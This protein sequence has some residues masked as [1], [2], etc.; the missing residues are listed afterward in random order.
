MSETSDPPRNEIDAENA[1]DVTVEVAD[2]HRSVGTKQA[3]LRLPPELAAAA[4]S[5]ALGVVGLARTETHDP[6][7]VRM[8]PSP[9]LA[10]RLAAGQASYLERD[11]RAFLAIARDVESKQIV[12]HVELEHASSARGVEHAR[13]V[14]GAA[15]AWKAL[16]VATQQH[17]LVEISSGLK[18]IEAAIDDLGLDG[19]RDDDAELATATR[20]LSRVE[21]HL[22][23]GAP[24]SPAD[25]TLAERTYAAA[26]RIAD[27]RLR[28]V[29]ALLPPDADS[30]AISD[31]P[32]IMRQLGLA[33]RALAV[34]AR[35]AWLVTRL[36][37]QDAQRAMNDLEHYAERFG[38]LRVRVDDAAFALRALAEG[39]E[40]AWTQHR[41]ARAKL[42]ANVL[43]LK[44]PLKSVAAAPV[45]GPGYI[46]ARRTVRRL[47]RREVTPAPRVSFDSVD[48]HR[49]RPPK[50]LLRL[51]DPQ[52]AIVEDWVASVSGSGPDFVEVLVQG[53]EARLLVR[54]V[55][56][57]A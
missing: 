17:Y 3:G 7:L 16:A 52:R 53:D 48:L 6:L 55:V 44:D 37:D 13:A 9:E 29:D 40:E 22:E 25:R 28:K 20:E 46:A 19:E 43:K 30:R 27:A 34:S 5:I 50:N 49:L 38:D 39:T 57:V 10:E 31:A 35:A 4:R 12:Q 32:K 41:Q 18:T 14:A 23:T 21:R 8:R 15:F 51:A 26:E 56:G 11:G 45:V 47:A 1:F 2:T 54:P 42:G 24:T 33:K 36:P